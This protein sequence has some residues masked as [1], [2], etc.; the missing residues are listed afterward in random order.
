MYDLVVPFIY[1]S[2]KKKKKKPVFIVHSHKYIR[3]Y[4]ENEG[5]N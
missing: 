3:H 5:S 2:L 4:R 1:D